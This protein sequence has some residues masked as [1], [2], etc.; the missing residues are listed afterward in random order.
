ML[1]DDRTSDARRDLEIAFLGHFAERRFGAVILDSDGRYAEFARAA[2]L[3]VGNLV[4][5]D[6]RAQFESLGAQLEQRISA[7]FPAKAT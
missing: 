5:P 3:R 1:L 7:L 2:V 6:D 4:D